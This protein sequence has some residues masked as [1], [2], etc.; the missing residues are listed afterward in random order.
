[1]RFFML[2][3]GA[4]CFLL[5]G[6]QPK[7]KGSEARKKSE[8]VLK[9]NIQFDPQTLDPRKSRGLN[10]RILINM[11]FEGLMRTNRDGQ[12]DFALAETMELSSDLKTYVFHLRD[13][14]WSNG[15]PVKASDFVYAW[16]TALD[17]KFP[18]ENAYQMYC[19]KHAKSIKNGERPLDDLG[20]WALDEKTLKVELEEPTPYFLELLTFTTFFPVHTSMDLPGLSEDQRLAQLITCGPFQLLKWKHN[21]SIEVKKNEKYW[22]ASVVK[23]SKISMCMVPEDTELK[24]FESKELDWAGS[25][26][27]TLSTDVIGTLKEKGVLNFQPFLG[28]YFFRVN[29]KQ[30]PFHLASMRK[31]LALAINRKAIVDHITQGNQTPAVGLVP[32]TMGLEPVSFSDAATEE[33]KAL[34]QKGLDEMG[35]TVQ[36]LP[37]ITLIYTSRQINHRIA[38]AVQQQWQEALGITVKLEAMEAKVY[39]DR[40]GQQDYQL[41]SGNWIADYNDPINFLEV[42]KF[43]K[44]SSNNTHWENEQYIRLLDQSNLVGHPEKRKE[45]LS[46]CESILMQEMPIIPLYHMSMVYAKNDHLKEIVM[47]PIGNLDFKW[48][49]LDNAD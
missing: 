21:D 13:A 16:K 5:S 4:A 3:L 20:A 22:D 26:M 35:V 1:M 42:F 31:A 45:I 30:P 41:A 15:D 23:L 34:F 33:A 38:Q 36:S 8:S 25:P 17:P 19:I 9:I 24:M 47:S 10:D 6:C 49:Y 37:E 18:S 39:F 14:S 7:P 32:R 12:A 40:L 46:K 48:A 44:A 2:L 29:I 43:N 28:T 11:L 27:G